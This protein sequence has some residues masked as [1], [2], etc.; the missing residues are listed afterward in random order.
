MIKLGELKNVQ[1]IVLGLC[2]V[3]ATVFSASILSQGVLRVKKLTDQVIEVTGSAEKNIMSDYIVWT[4]G[5][6]RR[7]AELKTAYTKLQTDLNKV[8]NYLVSKGI[9]KEEIETSPVETKTLYKKN[10]KGNST[11]EIEGY[12]VSQEVKVKSYDVTKVNQ[13][14][15]ES[16]ELLDK[17]IEF[18]SKPPKY[19]YT[20][21]DDL[22][23]EM[24]S[25]ATE[26]AKERAE[27]MVSSTGNKIVAIRSARMG[28]FQINSANSYDVSWYGNHDTSSLEKKIIAIAHVSFAIK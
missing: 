22:K 15:K 13:V 18:I 23:I 14:S 25:K 20:Q 7:D 9:E 24:L 28:K 5:F 10:E 17:D 26:N 11:N 1:I 16:T 6:S 8:K 2:I 12:I 19:F 4:S 21:L 27:K 3:I